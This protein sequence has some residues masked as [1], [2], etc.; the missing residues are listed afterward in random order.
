MVFLV[1]VALVQCLCVARCW[2]IYTAPFHG[3]PVTPIDRCIALAALGAAAMLGF[4]VLFEISQVG[5]GDGHPALLLQTATLVLSLLAGGGT[6]VLM[7]FGTRLLQ[8]CRRANSGFYAIGA[9]TIGTVLGA[10]FLFVVADQ[11]QFYRPWAGRAVVGVVDWDF[12]AGQEPLVAREVA[13]DSPIIVVRDITAAEAVYRCPHLPQV[14]LARYSGMP[15]AAWPAYREGTSV[16]LAQVLHAAI[17]RSTLPSPAKQA[18][19]ATSAR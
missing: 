9:A 16:G 19:T 11:E 3:V 13:C 15:I 5:S 7:A 14:V 1:A 12:M 17:S 6:L 18:S 2:A 8:L 10:Y 4:P